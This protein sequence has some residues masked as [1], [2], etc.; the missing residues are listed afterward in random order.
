M[1]VTSRTPPRVPR[2]HSR[3]YIAA[4]SKILRLLSQGMN[5]SATEGLA[6]GDLASHDAEPLEVPITSCGHDSGFHFR[7][8]KATLLFYPKCEEC[9]C[10]TSQVG[11]S[12]PMKHS[13]SK[14]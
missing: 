11:R 1:L 13:A 3:P 5:C 9:F 8:S 7:M 12:L 4:C 10:R 2:S 6:T 14:L